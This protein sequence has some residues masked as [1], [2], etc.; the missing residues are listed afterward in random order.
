MLIFV[1]N[2]FLYVLGAL[3]R[4][5]NFI[6]LTGLS[7]TFN[8]ALNVIVIPR[9][10][11][12]RGYDAT[13]WTT[14]AA[15][16]FLF[17]LGYIALSRALGRLSFLRPIL[18]ILLSGALMAAAMYPLRNRAPIPDAL[19]GLLVYSAAMVLSRGVTRDE[20]RMGEGIVRAHLR[21]GPARSVEQRGPHPLRV[22]VGGPLAG[23]V[24]KGV[25]ASFRGRS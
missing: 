2:S 19:L 14:V 20:L 5:A 4:Q 3:D 8:V 7:V 1:V 6:V 9:F 23:G 21:D 12:D 25:A 13:S 10:P 18:P 24:P 22:G 15:E 17:L 16:F 11:V